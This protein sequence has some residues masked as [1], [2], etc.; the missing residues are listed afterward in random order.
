MPRAKIYGYI[1]VIVATLLGA[2]F[3]YYAFIHFDMYSSLH[4]S[5]IDTGAYWA[6]VTPI[7]IVTLFVLATGFWVGYTILTI[8]VAPPMPEIVEKKDNS[9]FKAFLLC[10]VTA[11][12]AAL[13]VYGV[14][15]HYYLAI[16]I[17]AACITLVIL[18]MVFWVGIAIITTRSTLKKDK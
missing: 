8:K 10:L 12:L 18:G 3:V 14:V 11:A 5:S 4:F 13:F 7:A 9:K 2:A 6:V 15:N 16:A 17:P 1:A